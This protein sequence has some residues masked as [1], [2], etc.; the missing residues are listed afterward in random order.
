MLGTGCGG[1]LSPQSLPAHGTLTTSAKTG[2]HTPP[3]QPAPIADADIDKYID[4]SLPKHDR[5][6][7]HQLMKDLRPQDRHSVGFFAK[8]GTNYAN[9]K[10][11][12]KAMR[13]WASQDGIHFVGDNG[14]AFI[15]PLLQTKAQIAAFKAT[16]TQRA[17]RSGTRTPLGYETPTPSDA[18]GPFR[19]VYSDSGYSRETGNIYLPC[20]ATNFNELTGQT[21]YIYVGG[22]GQNDDG[23]DAGFQYSIAND[24][25]TLFSRD[26]GT[27]GPNQIN[28]QGAN[29]ACGQTVSYDLY[30]TVDPTMGLM[31]VINAS[32]TDVNG[33]SAPETV[34]DPANS[35]GFPQNG[36]GVRLKR[37]TTI[38]QGSNDFTNGSTFGIN[39][40]G[41]PEV[42]WSNCDIG[43]FDPPD[44]VNT[45]F[46]W[47][48]GNGGT[49][50]YPDDSSKIVVTYSDMADETDGINLHQ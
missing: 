21:G 48:D 38:A 9:T 35:D 45:I 7:M 33:N 30:S 27:D 28:A 44:N 40:D 16:V 22:F 23:L 32:G 5:K 14:R 11:V 8:D 10:A 29:Y 43:V 4:P 13:R 20:G 26:S 34:M 6:I 19:R 15:G 17:G 50:N 1:G 47:P 46:V 18:T 2:S 25:Y 3:A 49:Q 31:T 12:Y 36:D 41:T 37:M 42:A 24:S 39:F